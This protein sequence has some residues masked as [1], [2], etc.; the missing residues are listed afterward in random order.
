[1]PTPIVADPNVF[2]SYFLAGL[3]AAGVPKGTNCES[4]ASHA[5]DAWHQHRKLVEWVNSGQ[6]ARDYAAREAKIK[7]EADDAAELEASDAAAARM[8][9]EKAEKA[10]GEKAPALAAK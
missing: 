10:H 6:D 2:F 9:R 1:M 4:W 5:K 8:L 7:Q 3:A